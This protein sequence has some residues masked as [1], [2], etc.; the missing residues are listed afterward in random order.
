MSLL[1]LDIGTTGCKAVA[2]SLDGQVVASAY[3]EY[4]LYHPRPGWAELDPAE[5]WSRVEQVVGEIGAQTANDPV[6]AIG[7]SSQGEAGVPL[8]ADGKD[9][10]RSP[11]SFDARSVPHCAALEQKLGRRKLFEITGQPPA[12]AFTVP[13]LM[14][15]KE[16]EPE[17][18]SRMQKFLC[19]EDYA[20][21]KLGGVYATDWSL[22][23]RTMAFDAREKSY[24]AEICQA[25]GL[26]AD[27]FAPAHPTGTAVGKLLPHVAER[28]GLPADVV[29]A[30]GGHDQ[31]A[32]ALGGGVVS[33]GIALDSTGTVE[34]ITASFDE[35]AFSDAMLASSFSQT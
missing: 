1:G 12:G 18:F 33:G 19:F 28:L 5:V 29:L 7:I 14:W 23:G 34:C 6:Q 30:T 4:P 13:K 10:Y 20:L 11:V 3:R 32:G 16:A 9:L 35:P 15:L 31:P 27:I 21:F 25:A 26:D 17:V 8:D 2:F 24:S 22:A